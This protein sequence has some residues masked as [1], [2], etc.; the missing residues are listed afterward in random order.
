MVPVAGIAFI[1]PRTTGAAKPQSSS[2]LVL[3]A[4][5]QGYLVG[6][7]VII[8]AVTVS[9]MRKGVLLHKLILLE[10]CSLLYS[11]ARVP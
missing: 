4:W 2:G 10:V 3:E 11:R 7:L 6:S 9:N 8:A 5:A 1:E